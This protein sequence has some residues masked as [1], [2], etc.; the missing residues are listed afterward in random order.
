MLPSTL[1]NLK[2]RLFSLIS[3]HPKARTLTV[4]MP[5]DEIP[6]DLFFKLLEEMDIKQILNM[7]LVNKRFHRLI[8]NKAIWQGYIKQLFPYLI[9][10]CNEQFNAAP[11]PLFVKEYKVIKNKYKSLPFH[12]ILTALRGDLDHLPPVL[13]PISLR[14]LTELALANGH[15]KARASLENRHLHH[16]LKHAAITNNAQTVSALLATEHQFFT[17]QNILDAYCNGAENGSLHAMKA[18]EPDPAVTLGAKTAALLNACRGNQ[19]EIVAYLA[20][21]IPRAPFIGAIPRALLFCAHKSL[22]ALL[23]LLAHIDET[24]NPGRLGPA[25]IAALKIA[26]EHNASAISKVLLQKL[27]TIILTEEYKNHAE[28][29]LERMLLTT[30]EKDNSELVHVFLE[31]SP[32]KRNHYHAVALDASIRGGKRGVFHYLVNNP[33]NQPEKT[34]SEMLQLAGSYGKEEIVDEI[35]THFKD[36]SEKDRVATFQSALLNHWTKVI[37]VLAKHGHFA[38]P[39]ESIVSSFITSCTN[40]APHL[41]S[42]L[43]KENGEDI[44]ERDLNFGWKLSIIQRN[45]TITA[46]ILK[47]TRD[48]I[49]TIAMGEG[50]LLAFQNR[51]KAFVAHCFNYHSEHIPVIEKKIIFD[52]AQKNLDLETMEV[53]LHTSHSDI[54]LKNKKVAL[55]Q[56]A[57][58]Q[59]IRTTKVILPYIASELTNNERQLLVKTASQIQNEPMLKLLLTHYGNELSF[60]TKLSTFASHVIRH[61]RSV[62]SFASVC[63]GTHETKKVPA[64]PVMPKPLDSSDEQPSRAVLIGFENQLQARQDNS[65]DVNAPNRVTR[66]K[67]K[68]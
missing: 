11:F 31:C 19:P 57:R 33:S 47:Y 3:L 24:V 29:E 58:W 10:N 52:L 23:V 1:N 12:C 50:V 46:D 14:Y 51:A 61:P 30:V 32:S 38:I 18:L 6:Q 54:P 36:I 39:K 37:D 63:F 59:D 55:F 5:F 48:K 45:L 40:G 68:T 21:E 64:K 25:L 8:Q 62:F 17:D 4:P 44:P 20:T 49:S 27:Q 35:L 43:L 9:A 26:L 60:Y 66:R 13:H 53:I 34:P 42:K 16:V 67:A 41:A 22:N 56:A 65:V 15:Q 7:G 28:I 2:K